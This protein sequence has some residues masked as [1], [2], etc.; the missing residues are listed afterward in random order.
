MSVF[1]QSTHRFTP[2]VEKLIKEELPCVRFYP[3]LLYVQFPHNEE[4]PSTFSLQVQRVLQWL[5]AKKEV[6]EIV[7]LHVP[8][9]APRAGNEEVIRNALDSICVDTLD[10][11]VLDLSI[12]VILDGKTK[13]VRELH[14]YSS[15]NMGVLKQWSGEEGVTLLENVSEPLLAS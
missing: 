5:K 13:G 7:R 11:Q 8:G 3:R 1:G 15:G 9:S 12:D 4:E 14:L 6:R 2:F 10:W